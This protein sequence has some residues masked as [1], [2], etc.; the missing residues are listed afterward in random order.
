MI[1]PRSSSR[2]PGVV[3]LV[4]VIG[5]GA[6]IGLLTV[7]SDDTPDAAALPSVDVEVSDGS[8][9]AALVRA[10]REQAGLAVRFGRHVET[11]SSPTGQ[12]LIVGQTDPVGAGDVRD[13]GARVRAIAAG[14]QDIPVLAHAHA[15]FVAQWFA[16]RAADDSAVA[17]DRR[18]AVTGRRAVDAEALVVT[19]LERA[20]LA[21]NELGARDADFRNDPYARTLL[22]RILEALTIDQRDRWGE[23]ARDLLLTF[24][25]HPPRDQ[26][27]VGAM[28]D[29]AA[30]WAR[31][32][33]AKHPSECY[34]QWGIERARG[35]MDSVALAHGLGRLMAP[36]H[37]ADP[38]GLIRAVL[39][40]GR[41]G[42]LDAKL[43]GDTEHILAQLDDEQWEHA[44]AALGARKPTALTPT[45]LHPDALLD[46]F[47]SVLAE[48]R[49]LR[50]SA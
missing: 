2:A 19:D 44:Y 34:G 3:A 43:G 35:W 12:V 11:I 7:T 18:C 27:P 40:F 31:A 42:R 26:L 32:E 14:E 41:F 29:H 48:P 30:D 25:W 15:R 20:V 5:P 23:R 10:V 39:G 6:D 49:K 1:D 46:C 17:A 13:A 22:D 16:N 28:F 9:Q 45:L 24:L 4:P 50:A 21:M 37:A 38:V 36:Y 8:W 47:A 33:A